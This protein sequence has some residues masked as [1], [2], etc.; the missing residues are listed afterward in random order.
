[1]AEIKVRIESVIELMVSFYTG[2]IFRSN[3]NC[4]SCICVGSTN[5]AKHF[6]AQTEYIKMHQEG[7]LLFLDAT[8]RN[9]SSFIPQQHTGGQKQ[10]KKSSCAVI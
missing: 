7:V 9:Y 8:P 1:M 3:F 10:K 5:V 2:T 6:D 4:T